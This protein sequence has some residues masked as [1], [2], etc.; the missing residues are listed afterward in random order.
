MKNNIYTSIFIIIFY[1]ISV[2]ISVGEEI[3]FETPEIETFENGDIL[4]AYKGGKAIIDKKTEIIAEPIAYSLPLI[5][6]VV[7]VILLL[8]RRKN[9]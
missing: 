5:A 2:N 4:K 9:G 6:G 8:L 7:I 1:L 3:I